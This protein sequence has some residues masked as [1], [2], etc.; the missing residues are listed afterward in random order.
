MIVKIHVKIHL[1]LEAVGLH[2]DKLILHTCVL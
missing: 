1:L 2:A